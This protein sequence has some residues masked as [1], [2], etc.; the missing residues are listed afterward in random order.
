MDHVAPA[1][2]CRIFAITLETSPTS[3]ACC[4]ASC[5]Q[6]R[7]DFGYI[8]QDPTLLPWKTVLDNVLFPIK[9]QAGSTKGIATAPASCSNW[10]DCGSSETRNLDSSPAACVSALRYAVAWSTIPSSF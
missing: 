3:T 7:E 1:G 10:L 4:C 2:R 8:F 5:T 9:I 6:P